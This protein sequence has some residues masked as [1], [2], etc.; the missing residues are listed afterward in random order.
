M[1]STLPPAIRVLCSSCSSA[2]R[3]PFGSSA[4]PR[5]F[6]APMATAAQGRGCRGRRALHRLDGDVH[7]LA[8]ARGLLFTASDSGR[9]RAWAA[10][11]CFNRGYL[12]VSRGRVPA[13]AACG[14][15]LVTSHSGGLSLLSSAPIEAP[16]RRPPRRLKLLRAARRRSPVGGAP[17]LQVRPAEAD[18]ASPRPRSAELPARGPQ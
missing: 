1:Q 13:L 2:P 15:T 12:D 10:P 9:V 7:A 18:A 4:P 17:E 3:R 8:V 11:G 16:P 5:R 14:G 6:A